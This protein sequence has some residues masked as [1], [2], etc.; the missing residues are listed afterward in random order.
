VPLL[1]FAHIPGKRPVEIERKGA[2]Q[3]LPHIPIRGVDTLY[4]N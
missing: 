4:I 3:D 2:V 1:W